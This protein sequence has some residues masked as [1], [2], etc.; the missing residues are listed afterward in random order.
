M[1]NVS[2]EKRYKNGQYCKKTRQ[3]AVKSGM[4]KKNVCETHLV[5]VV[6]FIAKSAPD[7]IVSVLKLL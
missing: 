4:L 6:D 3:Y 5:P 7:R 1:D 2:C